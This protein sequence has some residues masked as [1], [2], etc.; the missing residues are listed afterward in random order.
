MAVKTYR[1]AESVRSRLT[2]YS[3]LI[4][5]TNTGLIAIELSGE[6]CLI[7][8]KHSSPKLHKLFSGELCLFLQNYVAGEPRILKPQA[9]NQSRIGKYVSVYRFDGMSNLSRSIEPAW[10][11]GDFFL[12]SG[13]LYD[14]VSGISLD[15]AVAIAHFVLRRLAMYKVLYFVSEYDD[16]IIFIDPGSENLLAALV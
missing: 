3:H 12:S 7:A 10:W 9:S 13:C 11:S 8:P 4:P 1:G 5:E 6:D 2:A 15:S 14:D 16:E